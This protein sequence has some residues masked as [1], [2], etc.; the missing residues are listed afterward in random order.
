MASRR[1]HPQR[2]ATH[3]E[4]RRTIILRLSRAMQLVVRQKGLIVGVAVAVAASAFFAITLLTRHGNDNPPVMSGAD[5]GH[6]VNVGIRYDSRPPDCLL[7]R[8]SSQLTAQATIVD[9]TVEGD[10]IAYVVSIASPDR[11]SVTVTSRDRYGLQ[12]VFNY[13]CSGLSRQPD[14][15]LAS[16]YFLIA[17]GCSG[18]APFLSDQSQ[19]T[20]P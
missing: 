19:V 17:T 15:A 5:C 20:I 9:Y 1:R 4:L 16:H 2:L 12:G 13:A 6:S 18:P 14:Q 8:Y 11:I 7:R 3:F 10:P